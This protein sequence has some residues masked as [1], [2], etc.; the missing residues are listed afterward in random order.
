MKRF[1][2]VLLLLALGL[3]SCNTE[4]IEKTIEQEYNIDLN[5]LTME[6]KSGVAITTVDHIADI[7]SFKTSEEVDNFVSAPCVCLNGGK[8]YVVRNFPEELRDADSFYEHIETGEFMNTIEIYENGNFETPARLIQL[9]GYAFDEFIYSSITYNNTNFYITAKVLINGE[10][11]PYIMTFSENGEM[12]ESNEL[13]FAVSESHHILDG[14]IYTNENNKLYKYSL[15]I[16]A[17]TEGELITDSVE[18]IFVSDNHLYVLKK[19]TT[20]NFD[21]VRNLY[22]YSTDTD[23]S[24][25]IMK[26]DTDGLIQSA[27]YD[28]KNEMLYFSNVPDIYSYK[29][30]K[31]SLVIGT[32]DSYTEV[33]HI[34]DDQIITGIGHNQLSIYSLPEKQSSITD[35]YVINVCIPYKDSEAFLANFDKTI[36]FMKANG[37]SVKL[38]FTY[39]AEN[40]AE[41]INTMAK[42]L[43]AGDTDFD[44]FYVDTS[45]TELLKKKYYADLGEY[46]LLDSY[47]DKMVPGLSNICT[48][49]DKHALVPTYVSVQSIQFD[50]S[51]EYSLPDNIDEIINTVDTAVDGFNG[52]YYF[53]EVNVFDII[54]PW[55]EEIVAN[56]MAGIVDYKDVE[57]DIEKVLGFVAS[58]ENSDIVYL[59][60]NALDQNCYMYVFQNTGHMHSHHEDL[61]SVMPI[62]KIDNNYKH[63]VACNW[64]AINPKSPH[65]DIA[66]VFFAYYMEGC[67]RDY[68]MYTTRF[69]KGG[70]AQEDI[71]AENEFATVFW[72]QLSDSVRAISDVELSNLLFVNVTNYLE[73]DIS[74][75][76]AVDAIMSQIKMMRNE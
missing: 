66:A 23:S 60:D 11:V 19:E 37:I 41:Y 70:V 20:E 71:G 56:Y 75:D 46:E 22:S 65:K 9:S 25:F 62:V 61:K 14:F 16:D 12:L 48:I 54:Y 28:S 68:N 73:G 4:H 35:E 18:I 74:L 57:D 42:K 26:I 39:A 69:Y 67:I 64:F 52:Q 3:C 51:M 47:F 31:L 6:E 45:M 53:S 2:A 38:E 29:D 13:P 58:I 33:I 30:G 55:M 15:P 44:M 1:V 10:Y 76:G 43:M 40:P 8:L 27:A 63:S 59:G 72:E 17:S 36:D 7:T 5:E 21:I 34:A 32:V 50:S 24:E 49:E